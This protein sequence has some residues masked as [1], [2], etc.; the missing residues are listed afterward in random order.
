VARKTSS[1][2]RIDPRTNGVT[3]AIALGKGP[4]A[5]ATGGDAVWVA[6]SDEGSVARIDPRTIASPRR[7]RWDTGRRPSR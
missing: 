1:V 4:A 7:S 2:S 3:Q 5:V 6:M